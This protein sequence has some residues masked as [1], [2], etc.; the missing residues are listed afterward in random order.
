MQ[1]EV[2]TNEIMEFLKEHMVTKGDIADTAIKSDID[3]IVTKNDIA[4]MATETD[5]RKMESRIYDKMDDKLA[6][7]KGDIVL[8]MRKGSK[9]VMELIEL[10]R[11]KDILTEDEELRLL[12]LQPFPQK[13]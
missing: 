5:L 13:I 3:D 7:L 6:D 1:K 11:E 8:L 10:L 12:A 4:D 2:T 9:G